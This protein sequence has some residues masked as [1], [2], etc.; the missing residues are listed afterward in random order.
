MS[1]RRKKI[2]GAKEAETEP[3]KVPLK[4]EIQKPPDKGA[5]DRNIETEALIR[6]TRL[7]ETLD[8]IIKQR[9]EMRRKSL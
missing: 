1:E 2:E 3:V 8:E 9:Q 4:E 5:P 7:E 6:L